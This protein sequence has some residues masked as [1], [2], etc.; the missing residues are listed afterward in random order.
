MSK[1]ET[2]RS[3]KNICTKTSNPILIHEQLMVQR[4]E[5]LGRV[6]NIP[7]P[8]ELPAGHHFKKVLFHSEG[9]P[10]AYLHLS[11]SNACANGIT[12]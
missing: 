2:L 1:V 12:L 4:I 3:V 7:S 8:S 10:F 5:I 11:N 6:L 9:G